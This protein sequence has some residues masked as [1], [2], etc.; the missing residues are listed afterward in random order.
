M[1]RESKNKITNEYNKCEKEL[2][3]KTEEVEILKVEISDLKQIL[4]L[5]DE[6]KDK[7]LDEPCEEEDNPQNLKNKIPKGTKFQ[8][9]NK[10]EK[11][12]E[13]SFNC[14]EC[15]FKTVTQVQLQKHVLVHC[16]QQKEEEFNCNKFSSHK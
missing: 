6:L 5:N 10:A 9:K 3:N 7:E 2:R 13:K 8:A 11:E 4:K 14:K 15:S 12:F 16:T 1:C